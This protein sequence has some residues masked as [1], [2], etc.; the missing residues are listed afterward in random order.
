M[1][2]LCEA[3]VLVR[4]QGIRSTTIFVQEI[5]YVGSDEKFFFAQFPS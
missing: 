5:L 4:C 2:G 3:G 1:K